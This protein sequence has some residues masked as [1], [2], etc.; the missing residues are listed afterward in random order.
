MKDFNFATRK[1]IRAHQKKM[2][3]SMGRDYP[4]IMK[5]LESKMLESLSKVNDTNGKR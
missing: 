1:E 4:V 2:K 5:Y 3:K